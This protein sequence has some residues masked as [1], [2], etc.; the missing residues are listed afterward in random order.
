M[1]HPVDNQLVMRFR[2]VTGLPVLVAKRELE[3][4]SPEEQLAR[5]V[6]AES[7]PSGICRDPLEESETIGP[8]IRDVMKVVA[9]R[10]RQEHERRIEELRKTDPTM[11]GF[12]SNGRGMCHRIWHET[13]LQLELVH[14][15]E[16]RSPAELNPDAMFD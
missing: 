5:I 2:R 3:E 8:I 15:I 6:K 12:L 11:A 14:G 13:K 7:R 16:W 10:V 9:E 4:F 1:K